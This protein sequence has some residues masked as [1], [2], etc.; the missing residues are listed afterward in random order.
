MRCSLWLRLFRSRGMYTCQF[1]CVIFCAC[2]F[3]DVV[4]CVIPRYNV[5]KT[6]TSWRKCFPIEDERHWVNM[7]EKG[8]LDIES[9]ECSLLPITKARYQARKTLEHA[10]LCNPELVI[11]RIPAFCESTVPSVCEKTPM[12]VVGAIKAV[13]PTIK[14]AVIP[15]GVEII[16][17][18]AFHDCELLERV[19]IPD[20]VKFICRIA[21]LRCRR[22]TSLSLPHG[23]HTVERFAFAGCTNMTS[24]RFRPPANRPKNVFI[25][26]AVSNAK[27]RKN[28]SL[29]KI[30]NLRNVI[31][32]ITILAS[33]CRA[34]H[35]IVAQELELGLIFA[36]CPELFDKFGNA[37]IYWEPLFKTRVLED[38]RARLE[39]SKVGLA[40]DL[41]RITPAIS[42]RKAQTTGALQETKVR[43]SQQMFDR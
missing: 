27:N 16:G 13:V 42:K 34:P 22:L 7:L 19:V 17:P 9:T 35:S 25:A 18:A 11:H 10:R 40:A 33:E 23:L 28:F 24:V 36:G 43:A 3:V 32:L 15:A 6:P 5:I 2:V 31:S 14:Q 12:C 29:T 38:K 1:V 4:M 30:A 21:F 8:F 37:S 20:S 26:W 41:V 39:F